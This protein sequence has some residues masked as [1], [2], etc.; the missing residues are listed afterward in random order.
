MGSVPFQEEITREFSLSSA[1]GHRV[2]A[3]I[4]KP[5]THS[6]KEQNWQY[7]DLKLPASRTV[8][9]AFLLP[10]PPCLWGFVMA[11]QR[12]WRGWGVR[13]V[14]ATD[15]GLEVLCMEQCSS[16][17]GHRASR[18]GAGSRSRLPPP[19]ASPGLGWNEAGLGVSCVAWACLHSSGVGPR[20]EGRTRFLLGPVGHFAQGLNPWHCPP[21]T[22]YTQEASGLCTPTTCWAPLFAALSC[23]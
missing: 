22:V 6:P 11:A 8:W 16:R 1:W 13:R 19:A 15:L 3:A 17:H 21:P 23:P 4:C 18:P 10:R 9:N 14:R 5:D 12:Q 2:K 20:D 7:L